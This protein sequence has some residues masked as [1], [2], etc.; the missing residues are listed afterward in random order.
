MQN[1]LRVRQMKRPTM[2]GTLT[3][4]L[5]WQFRQAQELSPGC[6]QLHILGNKIVGPM[7]LQIYSSTLAKMSS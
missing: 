3:R 1:N 5:R 4:R 7:I 2:R 6:I